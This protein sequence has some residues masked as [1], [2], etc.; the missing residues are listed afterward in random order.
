M[1][2]LKNL[3]PCQMGLHEE[4]YRNMARQYIWMANNPQIKAIGKGSY[5]VKRAIYLAGF[6]NAVLAMLNNYRP[7]AY[8]TTNEQ[9]Q[10]KAQLGKLARFI[11]RYKRHLTGRF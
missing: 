9:A 4:I 3:N 11:T 2:V 8:I 6:E 5:S 7:D 1:L 10:Q